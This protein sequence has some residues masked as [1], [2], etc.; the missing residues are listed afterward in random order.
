MWLE[1]I[2]VD[3]DDIDHPAVALA[4]VP[5]GLLLLLMTNGASA[6]P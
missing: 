2:V 3:A 5:A 1:Q 4:M 6:T